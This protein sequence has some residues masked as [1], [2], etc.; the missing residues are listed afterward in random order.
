MPNSRQPLPLPE[1]VAEHHELNTLFTSL[2]RRLNGPP[3]H[4]GMVVSLLDSLREHLDTHFAYEES[5]GGF[6]ELIR[7]APWVEERVSAL[8][9]EHR[10][11][12]AL[13]C[14]LAA[15]A[16][17]APRTSPN[18]SE[19]TQKFRSLRFGVV[20]HEAKEHDL[21]Q[22]VYVQDLGDKD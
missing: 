14:D 8:V 16:R 22:E 3:W 1:I 12:M 13:A 20:A 21:L 9:A 17:S 6:E 19:L 5:D 10:R 4:D 2:E 11:L 18:W 7:N 15:A